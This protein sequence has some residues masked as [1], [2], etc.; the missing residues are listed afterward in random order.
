MKRKDFNEVLAKLEEAAHH[1]D[2]A[3]HL[4]YKASDLIQAAASS[5]QDKKLTPLQKEELEPYQWEIDS[6]TKYL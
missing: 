3:E 5:L 6:A 1:S 2:A 4:E